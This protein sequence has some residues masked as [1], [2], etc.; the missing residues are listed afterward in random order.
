MRKTPLYRSIVANKWKINDITK[1]SLLYD[2]RKPVNLGSEHLQPPT[3]QRG[4]QVSH[5]CSERT[6]APPHPAK[7]SDLSLVRPVAAAAN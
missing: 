4:Q 5:A 2:S 7:E 6:P 3:T 1:T